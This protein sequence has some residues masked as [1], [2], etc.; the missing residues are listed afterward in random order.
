MPVILV[1]L[2][3]RSL[4][5][6][7]TSLAMHTRTLFLLTTLVWAGVGPLEAQLLPIGDPG[8]SVRTRAELERLLAEYEQALSSPAYSEAVKRSVRNDAE[9][10]RGR[11]TD[12]DFRVGD[13]IVLSVQGEPNIPD[14]VAVEAGPVIVLPLFG[15]IPLHG[16]LRSEITAH[17]TEAFS[18]YLR[19]PVVRAT[20]LT[21]IS[22]QGAV[23]RPCFC[24][25]PAEMLIGE[26]LMVAGGPSPVAN[27]E[28]IR[29]ERGARILLEGD[30]LQ[31]AIRRGLT[32]D[33]LNLQAGDQIV[34]PQQDP[35]G[36]S[37][38]TIGFIAGI[39]GTITGLVIILTR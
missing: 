14:T 31:E 28:G 30:A 17:L 19:D 25:V 20:G 27:M 26:T 13:R 21:R 8:S 11:L 37:L 6:C 36:R 4:G 22:V 15:E 23:G 39:V 2:T 3:V 24:T 9:V 34:V 16:V 5:G 12:G 32:L 18:H 1:L 29:L 33:Q 35:P 10:I 38:Q 7:V